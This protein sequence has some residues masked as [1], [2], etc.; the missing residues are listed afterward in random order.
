MVRP[1][2][3]DHALLRFLA[4]GGGLDVDGVRSAMADALVRAA[5]AAGQLGASQYAIIT[6]GL[7][8]VVRDGVVVTVMHDC[9]AARIGAVRRADEPGDMDGHGP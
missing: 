2:I 4:R 7:V 5:D 6:D 8:F 1:R 9:A 3:S